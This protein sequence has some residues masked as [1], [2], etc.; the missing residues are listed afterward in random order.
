MSKIASLTSRRYGSLSSPRGRGSLGASDASD[1]WANTKA[2]VEDAVSLYNPLS[3]IT[4][5]ATA[6]S[7]AVQGTIGGADP[8]TTKFASGNSISMS[9]FKTVGGICKPTN[10]PALAYVKTMQQQMNRVAQKKGFSKIGVDGAVGPGTL[11]LLAKIQQA[12]SGEVMG[13][14]SSCIYVAGDADVI[15]EQVKSYADSI[16]APVTVQGPPA[17]PAIVSAATGAV[18]TAPPGTGVGAQVAGAFS[19]MTGGQKLALA[20][21]TGGIGY[22]IYKKTHKKRGK[23]R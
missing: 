17:V 9:D 21:M 7:A 14:T 13:N 18:L 20:G 10:F 15:G 4:A 23:R 12:S 2:T 5:A 8:S 11:A 19:G 1:P 6:V 22:L 3:L 16:G